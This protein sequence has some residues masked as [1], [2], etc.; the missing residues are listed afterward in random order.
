MGRVRPFTEEDIAQVADLH[1][2]VFHTGEACSLELTRAYRSYFAQI[3]LRH[4][5]GDGLPSLVYEKDNGEI[6]GFL[7]VSPRPMSLGGRPIRAAV[8]SQFIVDPALRS[9]L[10]GVKLLKTY[11]SGPQELSIADE[12]NDIS[13]RLWESC[14]GTTSLLYSLYWIHLLQ[15]TRFVLSR[16]NTLP[17]LARRALAAPCFLI[18]AVTARMQQ[19]PFRQSEPAVTG[20]DLSRETLLP[21][22]R[23]FSRG[24]ALRPEYDDRLLQWLFEALGRERGSGALHKIAVRG[25]AG[26][27]LG[28][29]IYYLDD[30]GMGEVLRI[31]ANDESIGTV[32]DHLFHHAWRQGAAAL[33][34]RIEPKFMQQFREKNSQFHHRGYWV[35][36][37]SRNPEV[38]QAIHRGDALLTRLE[39]EW[40][41]RF[42][43]NGGAAD[44]AGA[45]VRVFVDQ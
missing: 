40:A 1:R 41:M 21:C 15:P 35:L 27:I 32:L 33:S 5:G 19:S 8:S 6:A 28:W 29:Y 31:G 42:R 30:G 7:G 44:Y 16:F 26:K 9:P 24:S 45:A 43:L 22:L 14:G 3:F 25:A 4:P 39:G 10:A 12:A 2:R 17:A 20:E 34:G 11:L 23:K 13:R 18:D 38:L 37:H 36:V